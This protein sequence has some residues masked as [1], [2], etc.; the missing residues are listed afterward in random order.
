MDK[1][2]A[3]IFNKWFFPVLFIYYGINYVVSGEVYPKMVSA[4]GRVFVTLIWDFRQSQYFD[5]YYVYRILPSLIIK[6]IFSFISD[7]RPVGEQLIPA[8]QILNIFCIVATCYVLDKIMSFFKIIPQKRVLAYILLLINFALLKY[9]FYLPV[10]TDNVALLL[11]TMLLYFYLKNNTWAIIACTLAL[12]FTWPMGYYQGLILIALPVHILPYTVPNKL[13]KRLIYGGA[14]LL[15]SFLVLLI[16]FIEKQEIWMEFAARIDRK[17]LPLSIISI[18]IPYYFFAKIFLN[19]SLLDIPLFFK[20]LN[21]KRI[22]YAVLLFI[23]VYTIVHLLDPKPT[24]MY[25]TAQTLRDPT[26][27]GLRRPFVYLISDISYFGVVVCILI[28]FWNSVAKIISQLGWGLVGA[29]GL[30]I[31]LFGITPQTRHLI[32]L[33]PWL[34]V[35]IVAALN[36]RDI[37]NYVYFAIAALAFFTSKIWLELNNYEDYPPMQLDKNGSMGLPH[38]KFW[39]NLGPWMSDQMYVIQGTFCLLVMGILFFLFY[40]ITTVNNKLMVVQRFPAK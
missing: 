15:I 19:K 11:S 33:L 18:I 31:L 32:N 16:I 25:S 1:F 3:I 14:L 23:L 24:A 39:M 7:V 5:M 29:I 28:L 4:D 37:P 21:Y 30:N 10:M 17:Y 27:F 40:K 26:L 13:Q 20:M 34:V 9:P 12:A 2:K 36:K 8:F 22:A 35:F 38:Q 6:S